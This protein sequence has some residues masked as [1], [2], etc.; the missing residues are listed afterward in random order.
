[1]QS[2]SVLSNVSA[3]FRPSLRISLPLARAF[4]G[5]SLGA[6]LHHR[7]EP[8]AGVTAI[9]TRGD[10]WLGPPVRPWLPE[11]AGGS[12]QALALQVGA[13]SALG[14]RAR[15]FHTEVHAAVALVPGGAEP[16]VALLLHSRIEHRWVHAQLEAAIVLRDASTRS[17]AWLGQL[18]LGAPGQFSVTARSAVQRGDEAGLARLLLSAQHESSMNYFSRDLATVGLHAELPIAPR[19]R[20]Q[21]GADYDVEQR[22]ILVM[23]GAVELRDRCKCIALQLYGQERLGRNGVD[24]GVLVDFL[25]P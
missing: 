11:A 24:V 19:L 14:D 16:H 6:Q 7:I 4:R 3:A 13:G 12:D 1:V 25:R 17:Q 23:R 15:N 20:V 8:F 5:R 21:G 2:T 10:P 22:T 9:V 18:Q